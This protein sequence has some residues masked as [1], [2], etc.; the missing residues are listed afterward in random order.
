M[1]KKIQI[2]LASIIVVISLIIILGLTVFPSIFGVKIDART[3]DYIDKVFDL[4]QKGETTIWVSNESR[5]G[6]DKMMDLVIDN[7]NFFW[8]DTN[9][10]ILSLG[11]I[12]CFQFEN[13]Y[14]HP[15]QLQAEIDN[16]VKDI[17][18]HTIS[19]QM[20]DYDKVI[21]IHDWLCENV[22]YEE[23]YKNKD[24][25]IYGTL[26]QKRAVCAGYAK[27]FAYLCE[28]EGIECEVLSGTS[29]NLQMIEVPHAWNRVKIDGK[30]SYFDVTWDDVEDSFWTRNWCG[31][32]SNEISE[33]HFLSNSYELKAADDTYNYYKKNNMYLDKYSAAALG[34]QIQKQG[35][36]LNIKCANNTVLNDIVK[37]LGN[38]DE[39]Q[40][41]MRASGL[42]Y[43]GTI[44]YVVDTN[45]N[46][47]RIN[48][49]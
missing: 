49:Q 6:A 28:K 20:S 37:A 38:S 42:T 26:V 39:L 45:A 12:Q 22:T 13:R 29:R 43:I 1:Q 32:S 16:V 40:N 44:K 23:D 35:K 9:V 8:L 46:C 19:S 5:E 3:N 2:I 7:P 10:R 41:V 47:I 11:N 15:E 33:S 17:H 36:T 34:K 18:A 30:W 27:A 24:Q 14:A 31:I 25:D 4:I 21:A 48:I